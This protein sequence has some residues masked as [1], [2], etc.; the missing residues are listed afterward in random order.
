MSSER[1]P[2]DGDVIATGALGAAL[3]LP[4]AEARA[5]AVDP[6]RNVVLQA[7]AGTGKTRVLVDR[8]LNL[9]RS[10]VD[11]G[12]ILAMTFT[13]KAA[14]EMRQRIVARLRQDASRSKTDLRRWRELRDR[15]GEIAICTIDAFCLSLL[16]EF[17]LEAG[18]TPGFDVADE[19]EVPRLVDEALDHTLRMGRILAR[20]D[21]AVCM[22]MTRLGEAQVRLALADLLARRSVA[23]D[24][25]ARFLAAVPSQL[26]GDAACLRL[27]GR[28]RDVLLSAPGGVAGFLA[29]GPVRHPAFALLAR[30]VAAL[31]RGEVR[32][33]AAIRAAADAIAQH[34]LTQEGRPRVRIPPMYRRTDC[35]SAAAWTRHREQVAALSRSVEEGL[36]AFHRDL[37]AVL[38]RGVRRLLRI[39]VGEYRRTL[40]RHHVLDFA[41]LLSRAVSLV[42]EMD[43]FARSRYRLEARYHHVLVD[44]FQDTSPEQWQLIARLIEAWGEGAGLAHGALPPSIFIV[45]DRKQSIYGFRDADPSV[46][47]SAR[48]LIATLRP[49]D[50]PAR[51]IVTSF[52]AVPP[53]LRF[54]N[55]L[56]DQIDKVPRPDAFTFDPAERFPVDRGPDEGTWTLGA[57]EPVNPGACVG[58]VV[59]EDEGA[60]A[61]AMAAEIGRLLAS[62]TVRDRRGRTERSVAPSDVALLFRSRESHHELSAALRAR[63]IPAYVYKGLGFFDAEEIK[64]A[65]ALVRYLA[66]PSSDLRAAA[67]L[68]SRLVRIS[69]RALVALGHGPAAALLDGRSVPD[70]EDQAV[71]A[72]LRSA[73]P[74]WLALVDRLPPAELIDQILGEVAYEDEIQGPGLLQAQANLKKLR[75]IIRRAQNRGYRTLAGI[76]EHLDRLSTG[77]ESNATVD[78][79]DAVSLMT[80]HAAK[81]LEFPIVFVVNL[82]RGTGQSRPPIRASLLGES[83]A[84]VVSI[85]ALPSEADEDERARDREETKRLLYVAVTRAKDRLYLS[86]ALKDGRLC[87]ARGSLAEVLPAS[88]QELLA[89]AATARLGT[90]LDWVPEPGRDPHAVQVC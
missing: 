27:A 85:G 59:R 72:Q 33:P 87:P 11:P 64:D 31:A 13:R 55:D 36:R 50:D 81:G 48:R 21:P 49:G 32:D 3:A 66:D 63:G 79:G 70:P 2:F 4:D 37:N 8:Y 69:D 84:P 90:C 43:E 15:L 17:P 52:R 45:G 67:F 41:E 88:V 62:G 26:T 78:A 77:D 89:R 7:S 83:R 58:V 5:A 44:E 75:W 35:V 9:L 46:L 19:T 82:S 10:G 47:D 74:R 1:L 25:I 12:N 40:D 22:L 68:R 39:A 53:L 30:D 65:L 16:Q 57:A 29:D 20:R 42:G 86:S 28:L 61:E 34:F 18:V 76:V 73:L 38:A 71:L 80:V 60:C 23:R 56:F 51:W 54:V 6:A 14:A 24:A